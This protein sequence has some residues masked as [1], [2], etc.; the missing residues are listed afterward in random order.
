M[1]I[2]YINKQNFLKLS[3]LVNLTRLRENEQEKDC[4]YL[5]FIEHKIHV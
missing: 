2:I 4:P 5:Y 1:T 3:H